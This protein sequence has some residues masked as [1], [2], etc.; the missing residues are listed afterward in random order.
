M[1]WSVGQPSADKIT[2]FR[3][4]LL[5][6]CLMIWREQNF[7]ACLERSRYC[8][9]PAFPVA[10]VV[11]CLPF[12]RTSTLACSLNAASSNLDYLISS[13]PKSYRILNVPS[14]STP[15]SVSAS[16]VVSILRFTALAMFSI[17]SVRYNAP[18]KSE[19]FRQMTSGSFRE[20]ALT[21][22]SYT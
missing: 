22:A 7:I 20:S 11:D 4:L 21:I 1:R 19:R 16:I 6:F 18:T 13:R 8:N 15:S 12:V 5:F 10:F 14:W 9:R 17:S 2:Q 3:E